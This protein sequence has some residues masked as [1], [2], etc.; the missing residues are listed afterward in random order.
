M[1][2]FADAKLAEPEPAPV[3]A[4][5]ACRERV[6]VAKAELDRVDSAMLAFR[7]LHKI[8]TDRFGRLLA[9]ESPT[10][11]GY[12]KIQAEWEALLRRR[13]AAVSEWH[14]C[15]HVW[16]TVKQRKETA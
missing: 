10:L 9:V 2:P 8:R 16:A 13:D 1:W 4:E 5:A 15:L 6:R 14:A 12:G 3:D 7:T 11:G